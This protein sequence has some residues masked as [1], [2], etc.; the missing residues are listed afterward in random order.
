MIITATINKRYFIVP[1]LCTIISSCSADRYEPMDSVPS[2]SGKYIAKSYISEEGTLGSTRYKV[3]I[4]KSEDD[5]EDL[6]FEGENGDISKITWINPSEIVIPFC[7]GSIYSVKSILPYQTTHTVQ[8]RNRSSSA[9]RIHIAT[10]PDTTI[11]GH[12]YCSAE[13]RPVAGNTKSR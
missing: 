11:S 7:F 1:L 4:K 2:P 3:M 8:F 10:A 5:N 13:D 9:I 6:V 12:S